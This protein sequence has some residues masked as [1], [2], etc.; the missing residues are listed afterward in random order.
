VEKS[1]PTVEVPS[2]VLPP[3]LRP[4]AA[5]LGNRTQVDLEHH[6]DRVASDHG[7]QVR[8][9]LALVEQNREGVERHG[10]HVEIRRERARGRQELLREGSRRSNGTRAVLAIEVQRSEWRR[11]GPG[12]EGRIQIRVVRASVFWY[13]LPSIVSAPSP[14]NWEKS[15]PAARYAC[16]EPAIEAKA[17]MERIV[18]AIA[19]NLAFMVCDPCLR[20]W[21]AVLR[22]TEG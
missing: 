20:F 22:P 11:L 6:A 7:H 16:A 4:V 10:R 19:S 15:Q 3:K 5:R 21:I 13:E 9:E 17:T 8:E 18:D 12:A 14:R 2:N 1:I